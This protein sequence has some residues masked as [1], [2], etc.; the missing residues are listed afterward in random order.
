M[1][2]TSKAVDIINRIV[3]GKDK[4]KAYLT[5]IGFIVFFGSAIFMIFIAVQL[6]SFF[7]LPELASEPW[8]I[9]LSMPLLWLGLFFIFWSIFY[10][11]KAKG[12]PVPINP[13]Q[14]LIVTG[15]YAYSRNPMLTGFFI[16]LFGIGVLIK[17]VFL[18]FFFAPLFLAVMILELKK[19]EEP[20]L[21]KRFGEEYEI[22]KAKVPMFLFKIKMPAI[23]IKFPFISGK[24]TG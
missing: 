5:P 7:E 1:N 16:L 19:I 4:I 14:S 20:E 2:I 8:N 18:T 13:P 3:T 17:S 24:K 23:T 22:Y 15:P 21:Q 9:L 11:Y 10:F 6:D 12:T